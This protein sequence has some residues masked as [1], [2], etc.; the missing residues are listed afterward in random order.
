M[1]EIYKILE[2]FGLSFVILQK[3]VEN[4]WNLWK[5]E[6]LEVIFCHFTKKIKI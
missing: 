6:N 4:L 5:F 1:F 3:N 2:T